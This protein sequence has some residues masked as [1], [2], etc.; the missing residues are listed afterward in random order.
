[1]G[2]E[3][4]YL[5]SQD[6]WGKSEILKTSGLVTT[7]NKLL[8]SPVTE[9]ENLALGDVPI[10]LFAQETSWPESG[11]FS[12]VQYWGIMGVELEG[13]RLNEL[14]FQIAPYKGFGRDYRDIT[15]DWQMPE[16]QGEYYRNLLQKHESM[17]GSAWN[18]FSKFR[19]KHYGAIKYEEPDYITP[20]LSWR[21]DSNNDRFWQFHSRRPK[22]LAQM[23]ETFLRESGDINPETLDSLGGL[24]VL[25]HASPE[26]RSD[27]PD[28]Y[29]GRVLGPTQIP[30]FIILNTGRL[31]ES[32]LLERAENLLAQSA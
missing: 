29:K 9:P 1:M 28:K 32:K 20:L 19:K 23:G 31:M 26:L 30:V 21:R 11:D 3:Q 12:V 10:A 7:I 5:P 16:R 13:A 8:E 6:D 25:A 14:I 18:I 22:N 17:L 15:N 4:L 2:S 24:Y 27:W